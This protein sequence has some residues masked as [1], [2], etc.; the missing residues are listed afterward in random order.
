[1]NAAIVTVANGGS[2]PAKAEKLKQEAK[3]L[4][5]GIPV[6]AW[7]NSYPPGSPTHQ[8][9]PY[10]FKFHAIQEVRNKGHD[11]ILW[12]DSSQLPIRPFQK[13]FDYMEEQGWYFQP[14]GYDIGTWCKDEALKPLGITREEAFGIPD[15]TGCIFGLNMENETARKF[16]D[17][18]MELAADGVTFPGPWKN[19]NGSCSPDKRV[20]GHRHDQAAMSVVRVQMEMDWRWSLEP[21][22]SYPCPGVREM[23]HVCFINGG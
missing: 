16:F 17:R 21:W 6:Y 11:C 23:E 12:L 15:L 18:M 1:M 3:K 20:L 8:Q 4:E 2:Y 14:N 10:A 5:P 9:A 7:I 13:M 19:I 22:M